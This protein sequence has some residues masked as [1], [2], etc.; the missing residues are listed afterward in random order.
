MQAILILRLQSLHS[1]KKKKKKHTITSKV[2]RKPIVKRKG[3]NVQLLLCSSLINAVMVIYSVYA[4][5]RCT[6]YKVLFLM[7]VERNRDLDGKIFIYLLDIKS[8]RYR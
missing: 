2:I 3:K 5:I 7:Y 8:K 6:V 1:N 4:S